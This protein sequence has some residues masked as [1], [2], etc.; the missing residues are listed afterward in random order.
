MKNGEAE[1]EKTA[2]S[3][4]ARIESKKEATAAAAAEEAREAEEEELAAAAA[5]AARIRAEAFAA[6][7]AAAVE[8]C[9]ET[10]EHVA[11]AEEG[12]WLNAE[13]EDVCDVA[14]EEACSSARDITEVG[15]MSKKSPRCA[16]EDTLEVASPLLKR[17]RTGYEPPSS[18]ELDRATPTSRGSYDADLELRD[19]DLEGANDISL[20]RRCADAGVNG[21][22]GLPVDGTRSP[23]PTPVASP[24]R[25]QCR[26]EDEPPAVLERGR[27]ALADFEWVGRETSQ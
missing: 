20:A 8:A 22:D 27:T 23:T 10:E 12:G 18:L 1:E 15:M 25:N 3:D 16:D 4:A 9:T 6:A 5:E 7:A 2:V 24:L 13:D 21:A 17:C 11:A 26:M 14:G 19:A